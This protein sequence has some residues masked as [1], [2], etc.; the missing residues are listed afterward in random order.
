MKLMINPASEKTILAIISNMPQSLLITGDNG[1]GLSTISRHIAELLNIKPIIILPEKDE[2]IDLEKGI[3][4]VDIMR[5]LYTDTRTKS[6]N[7]RIIII[8]YA[9]RMTQQSQNAF[10]KLLEEPGLNLHF[11]LVSSS[12]AKLLPTILSRTEKLEIKPVT[13]EQSDSLLDDLTVTDTTKRSQLLFMASGLPAEIIRLANDEK[14][15]GIRSTTV[16]DA[17]EILQGS[18]YKKLLVAQ[19]YKDDRVTA[20]RLLLDAANILKRSVIANPQPDTINMIEKILDTYKQIEAN[21]NIRLCLAQMV[22]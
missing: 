14:Y 10:L 11:I 9:E 4:S 5:R 12:K 19:K 17:R 13:P 8:D 2:K 7:K 18:V 15:F 22:L 3:I 20:L 21:G 1:V 6:Q 16:R